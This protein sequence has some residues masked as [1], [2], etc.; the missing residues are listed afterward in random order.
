MRE[1]ARLAGLARGG[2]AAAAQAFAEA[3]AA[4]GYG[5]GRLFTLVDPL[6]IV[7]TGAGV[8]AMDLL[9][10]AIRAAI[11]ESAI[12]G[13]GADV[14]FSLIEDVDELIFKAATARALGAVDLEFA[15]ADGN[16]EA[17]IGQASA[18]SEREKA[19]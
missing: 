14:D 13:D 9:E 15:R 2:D 18:A 7:I 5:L 3:G 1:I 4:I 17:A 16:A 11:A 8:H 10:P 19:A 6:P 12:D